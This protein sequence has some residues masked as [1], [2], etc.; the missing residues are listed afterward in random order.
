MSLESQS[1]EFME[2]T[3]REPAINDEISSSVKVFVYL[4]V[5]RHF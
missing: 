1:S 3:Q 2:E 5:Y 4:F